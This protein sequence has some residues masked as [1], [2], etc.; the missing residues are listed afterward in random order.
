M[1]EFLVDLMQNAFWLAVFLNFVIL[2]GMRIF[3]AYK[4][5]KSI[6]DILK[7]LLLP[8]SFGYL[9]LNIKGGTFD[10]IYK[11]LMVIMFFSIGIGAVMVFYTHFA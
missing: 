9:S 7:I 10:V 8:F 6:T 4:E 1:L 11:T 3:F 5:K 2:F